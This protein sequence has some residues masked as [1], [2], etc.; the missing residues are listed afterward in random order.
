MKANFNIDRLIDFMFEADDDKSRYIVLCKQY[1]R[2]H[3]YIPCI[4]YRYP[5]SDEKIKIL[6]VY[7]S[8]TKSTDVV[9]GIIEV[10]EFD[11]DSRDRLYCVKRAMRRWYEKE[12]K[13]QRCPSR[14][15]LERITK[16]V[17]G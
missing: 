14:E 15:F 3:G 17:I 7:N 9:D 8:A 1:K 13:W 6:E 4:D 16:F 10:M 2:K 11:S 5:L 12:T